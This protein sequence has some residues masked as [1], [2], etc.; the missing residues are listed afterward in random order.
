MSCLVL[1]VTYLMG[2][3]GIKVHRVS[4]RVHKFFDW[5]TYTPI[6]FP[7]VFLDNHLV[8]ITTLTLSLFENLFEKMS[9]DSRT[10]GWNGR[11]FSFEVESACENVGSP[12]NCIVSFDRLDKNKILNIGGFGPNQFPPNTDIAGSGVCLFIPSCEHRAN[13]LT[14]DHILDYQPS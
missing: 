2:I 13:Q 7:K 9:Y 12:V 8:P 4:L 6:D 3:F 11:G 1:V 10:F 5:L 14:T